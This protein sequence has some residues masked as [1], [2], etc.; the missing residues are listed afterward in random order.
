MSD[1]AR[2]DGKYS[3]STLTLA[4][5]YGIDPA[6][7][8]N[9]IGNVD[10]D[11]ADAGAA[12][13]ENAE[14]QP[15]QHLAEKPAHA[16]HVLIDPDRPGAP[17]RPSAP[18]R[19]GANAASAGVG[20][21]TSTVAGQSAMRNVRSGGTTFNPKG[22]VDKSQVI[23]EKE[24]VGGKNGP[25]SWILGILLL[26]AI[27][28]LIFYRGCEKPRPQATVESPIPAPVIDSVV[29]QDSTAIADSLAALAAPASPVE[30]KAKNT[31]PARPRARAASSSSRNV[32]L[33]TTSSFSAQERLA[34]LRADGD[35]KARIRTV[36]KD[37]ATLYQVVKG[38]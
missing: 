8:D 14:A 37:G 4:E 2:P 12:S 16:K 30:S 36:K 21:A 29:T 32:A 28:A 13:V 31:A 23:Y 27:A 5:R 38:K 10:K 11:R 20:A 18:D 7:L 15:A 34:E 19:P 1:L 6:T 33:S 26:G 35:Q 25:L 17:G 24:Y 9:I 22:R 3:Q